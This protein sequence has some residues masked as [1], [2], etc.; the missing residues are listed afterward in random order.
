M[1]GG[2]FSGNNLMPYEY[3]DTLAVVARKQI[4]PTKEKGINFII[5]SQHT[6]GAYLK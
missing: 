6:V 1:S 4:L 2:W 3:Q 5:Y